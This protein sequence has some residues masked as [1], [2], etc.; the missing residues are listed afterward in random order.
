MVYLVWFKNLS[1]TSYV[2]ILQVVKLSGNEIAKDGAEAIV[3][4]LTSS[5]H[6][7]QLDLNCNYLNYFLNK[8]SLR[9]FLSCDL[10]VKLELFSQHFYRSYLFKICI[11]YLCLSITN[12]TF[13]KNYL[14]LYSQLLNQIFLTEI[15]WNKVHTQWW[16]GRS[17]TPHV[18]SICGHRFTTPWFGVHRGRG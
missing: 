16:S 15:S 1:L 10:L 2:V 18:R 9:C 6:L 14:I 3:G 8:L 7:E 12:I 5:A 11:W 4:A 17:T 13:K